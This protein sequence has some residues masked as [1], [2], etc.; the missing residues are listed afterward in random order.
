MINR[1]GMRLPR[2]GDMVNVSRIMLKVSLR[3][4]RGSLNMV[5]II[6]RPDHRLFLQHDHRLP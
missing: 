6:L 2:H 1:H 4:L 5:K 3:T